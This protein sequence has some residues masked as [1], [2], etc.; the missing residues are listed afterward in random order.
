MLRYPSAQQALLLLLLLVPLF[1]GA[2][3]RGEHIIPADILFQNYPWA[4]YAPE[5]WAGPNNRLMSDIVAAFVPWYAMTKQALSE[6]HW[7]LWNPGEYAG[8]PLLANCQSAVLYPPRL[9]HA[10]L[11][12][13]PATTLYVLL[14]LWFCGM[15][16]FVCARG[17]G[18][19]RLP[20]RFVSIAW[21][22]ASYNVIWCNWPLPDVSA[23]L[24]L[25]ILAVERS[26][27]G[28]YRQGLLGIGAAGSLLILGGHPETAFSM[29]FALGLYALARIASEAPTAARAAKILLSLLGGWA[30]VAMVCA[31][32]LLPFIEYLLHSATFSERMH[33][34][35]ITALPPDALLCFWAPK[36]YGTEADGNWYG[37]L[38][39]NRY[40]MAYPG[41][42]VWACVFALLAGFRRDTAHRGRIIALAITTGFGMA[43]AFDVPALSFVNQLPFFK[44][45]LHTYHLC[46]TFFALPLLGGIG[47]ELWFAHRIS[48]RKTAIVLIPWIFVGALLCAGLLFFGDLIDMVK[49]RP[50]VLRQLFFASAMAVLS[51]LLLL[52]GAW[53]RRARLAQALLMAVLV[54]DLWTINAGR[55]TTMPREQVFPPTAL[56]GTLQE[57]PKP[58]RISAG[59]AYIASGLFLLYG[60]ED[61]F[62]YDGLYPERMT[63]FQWTL[64]PDV[65]NG[66][67]P[68]CAKA[69]YLNEPR[70]K[71]NFPLDDQTYFEKLEALDGIEIY[72]NK[73]AMPRA[74]FMERVQVAPDTETLFKTLADP[75]FEHTRVALVAESDLPQDAADLPM[76]A[77]ATPINAMASVVR[78][79]TTEV[80]VAASTDRPAILVLADA[81][82]PGWKA[83]IDGAPA[84][85]FPVDHVFRGLV[86]P[87]G[88]HTV[89]YRYLP[90]TFYSG[91]VLSLAGL[92]I[93]TLIAL[94]KGRRP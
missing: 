48:M 90:W 40:T 51:A 63:T 41:M 38:D 60:L 26:V 27:A 18:L 36:F 52:G 34:G 3:L 17:I 23:W 1:P 13:F 12:L 28:Q 24:P 39:S 93:G 86:L 45:M 84:P 73:R 69:Y 61:W 20:S 54:A 68:L 72:R 49:V 33:G 47:L 71:A 44:T 22:F 58:T 46:F 30:L 42:A 5:G 59:D 87:P 94:R 9:L 65:W 66:A 67:E 16:A 74:Y 50:Y 77:P 19:D 21:M 76:S 56:T 37:N 57:L 4:A 75:E 8:M 2:F 29:A 53:T 14:K 6:G 89:L 43:A 83:Y 55:N 81:Y 15:T 79:E 85:L 11:P 92:G 25:L 82:Y 32:Q 78:H 62:A 70:M 80:E 31:P 64:G 88:K 91:L 10:A 35:K 7:P